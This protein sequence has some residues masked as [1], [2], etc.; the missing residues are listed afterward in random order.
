MVKDGKIGAINGIK[1]DGNSDDTTIQ[2]REIWPGITF[3]VAAAM[4]QEGMIE[5]GFK[6]AQGACETIWSSDGLG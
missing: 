6:T 2:A 3:A 4:I 1:P 5:N